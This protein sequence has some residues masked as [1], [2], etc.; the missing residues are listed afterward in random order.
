MQKSST[1]LREKEIVEVEIRIR[2]DRLP[3]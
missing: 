1:I 3:A 2:N